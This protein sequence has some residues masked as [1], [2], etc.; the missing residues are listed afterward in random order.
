MRVIDL[1]AA[2]AT[3]DLT[4]QMRAAGPAQNAPAPP[5]P[6]GHWMS[7][8]SPDTLQQEPWLGSW[9]C[10]GVHYR[11][12][13]CSAACP[14]LRHSGAARCCRPGHGALLLRTAL[15]AV[16]RAGTRLGLGMDSLSLP[17]ETA[18][19]L[20]GAGS[21]CSANQTV[22]RG[23]LRCS[24]CLLPGQVLPLPSSLCSLSLLL[25]P[26]PGLCPPHHLL[27]C[28]GVGTVTQPCHSFNHT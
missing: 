25:I 7:P 3:P 15:I 27:L 4:W 16:P 14:G 12:A 26:K 21:E 9:L 11:S 17:A 19:C 20:C 13:H 28:P 5:C 24:A 1:G 23:Q 6:S 2:G 8:G 18:F 10:C 22:S